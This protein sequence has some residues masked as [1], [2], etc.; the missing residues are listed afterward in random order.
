MNLEQLEGGQLGEVAEVEVR[1]FGELEE[2]VKDGSHL[3]RVVKI[4]QIIVP[5]SVIISDHPTYTFVSVLL[6]K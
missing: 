3:G 2:L 5:S 1:M 6:I 4:S